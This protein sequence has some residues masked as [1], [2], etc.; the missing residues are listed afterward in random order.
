MLL[1]TAQLHEIRDIISR[2]HQAFVVN[3]VGPTA[4]DAETL[5]RLQDLGLIQ[6]GADNL[7]EEAYLY[8]QLLAWTEAP[9]VQN[10]TYDEF[11]QH[12][13]KMR[14]RMTEIE[15]RASEWASHSAAQ[16]VVGLGNRVDQAT[17]NLLIEADAQLR[18]QMRSTIRDATRET[19]AK[20]E[21]AADLKSRLGWATGDWTRDLGRIAATELQAARLR[22]EAD[23]LEDK[24]GDEVEV[25]RPPAPDACNHCKRLHLGSDGQPKIFKLRDLERNGTNVG[26]RAVE[27]QPVVGTIH[28]WCRCPLLRVPAGWGFDADGSMVPGGKYGERVESEEEPETEGGE[29][30]LSLPREQLQPLLVVPMRKSDDGQRLAPEAAAADDKAGGRAPGPGIG[31]NYMF[32]APKRKRY[33]PETAGVLLHEYL[34]DHAEMAPGALHR[35]PHVWDFQEP[36]RVVHILPAKNERYA[37]PELQEVDAVEAR[38]EDA[39]QREKKNRMRPRNT[40]DAERANDADPERPEIP[41]E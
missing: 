39:Y 30:E 34:R 38:R 14:T 3:T 1:T 13:T 2:H 15:R 32:G 21:T 28:P 5:Q 41:E 35:D 16:Y 26:R 4:V 11:K 22:G 10:M 20:R 36:N 23:R 8:G 7:A 40:A 9:E 19:I 12:V 17:G 27:W 31:A 24:H 18:D 37:A 29:F 25:C 33:D 6:Q